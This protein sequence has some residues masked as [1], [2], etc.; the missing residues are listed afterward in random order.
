MY[1][2]VTAGCFIYRQVKCTNYRY[3]GQKDKIWLKTEIKKKTPWVR[4]ENWDIHEQSFYLVTY[5]CTNEGGHKWYDWQF[6]V[7]LLI[8][9]LKL[10]IYIYKKS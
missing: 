10:T 1:V 3:M 7:N 9:I 5:I 6:D 8:Y 4:D 2:M